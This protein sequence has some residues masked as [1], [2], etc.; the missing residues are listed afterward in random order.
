M[1]IA[2]NIEQFLTSLHLLWHLHLL[3]ESSTPLLFI[4]PSFQHS[5]PNFKRREANKH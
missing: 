3:V 1:K 2:N 4:V 5:V